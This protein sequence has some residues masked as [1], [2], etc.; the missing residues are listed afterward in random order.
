MNSVVYPKIACG[1]LTDEQRVERE[2]MIRQLKAELRCEEAKLLMLKKLKLSQQTPQRDPVHLHNH[3][4]ART[5]GGHM[6]PLQRGAAPTAT[7]GHPQAYRPPFANPQAVNR[8]PTAVP[9]QRQPPPL[10]QIRGEFR[11]DK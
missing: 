11:V 2:R 10:T 4:N 5:P 3:T 1:E 9:G 6:P 7:T 8:H